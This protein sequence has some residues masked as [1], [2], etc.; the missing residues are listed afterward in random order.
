MDIMS[1]MLC[2]VAKDSHDL[3]TVDQSRGKLLNHFKSTDNSET[4][5]GCE[6]FEMSS[7]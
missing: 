7:S 4:V 5:H 3:V 1:H 6:L 2:A